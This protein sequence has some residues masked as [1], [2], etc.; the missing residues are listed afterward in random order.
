MPT[1]TY[2]YLGLLGWDYSTSKAP[3]YPSTSLEPAIKDLITPGLVPDIARQSAEVSAGRGVAGSP[4]GASTAVRMS[5][6]NYLQRLGLANNLLSGEASRTLPYQITPYQSAGLN[7]QQQMMDLQREIARLH[8][9]NRGIA[10]PAGG[11]GGGRVASTPWA[12]FGGGPSVY[13]EHGTRPYDAGSGGGI[14]SGGY[15]G[16]VGG[17]QAPLSDQQSLDDLYEW[18]GWDAPGSSGSGATGDEGYDPILGA[19]YD[20]GYGEL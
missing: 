2:P 18:F 3:P 13:A 7:Y 15:M 12:G 19:G 17:G 5:E 8:Y 6:Q 14:L 9:G 11:G 10:H 1:T 20:E 16:A 4:A